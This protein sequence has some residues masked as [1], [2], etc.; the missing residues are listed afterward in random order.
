MNDEHRERLERMAEEHAARRRSLSELA[1]KPLPGAGFGPE[2]LG[3]VIADQVRKA[4]AG[5]QESLLAL[6]GSPV[7]VLI[8]VPAGSELTPLFNN[9]AGELVI[10]IRQYTPVP[11]EA[12]ADK[13][14][15][16][17]IFGNTLCHW[18]TPEL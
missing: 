13:P 9:P 11:L 14:D 1:D 10:R 6:P 8:Q 3:Q 18:P 17:P 15:H 7:N 4:L 2:Q 16:T 12:I 5:E